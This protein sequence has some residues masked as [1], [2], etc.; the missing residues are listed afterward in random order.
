MFLPFHRWTHVGRHPL[1]TGEKTA[2]PC[3][4]GIQGSSTCSCAYGC[5]I[6]GH[7]KE[8]HTHYEALGSHTT[9]L[10]CN[11]LNLSSNSTTSSSRS[12]HSPSISLL[13]HYNIA[14]LTERTFSHHLTQH[15]GLWEWNTLLQLM[16]SAKTT[17]ITLPSGVTGCDAPK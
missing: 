9:I 10:I 1:H 8:N 7:S 4:L 3:T 11:P 5:V 13:L 17:R 12:H 15:G 14:L 2:Q 16:G 6:D